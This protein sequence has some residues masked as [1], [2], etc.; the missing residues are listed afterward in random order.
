MQLERASVSLWDSGLCSRDPGELSGALQSEVQEEHGYLVH[1]E[2]RM[3]DS[4]EERRQEMT[5]SNTALVQAGRGGG[6]WMKTGPR[7]EEERAQHRARGLKEDRE[8]LFHGAYTWGVGERLP[9]LPSC[10]SEKTPGLWLS[11]WPLREEIRCEIF[12]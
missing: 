2:G 12:S 6:G 4:T 8:I 5:Q 7:T 3:E 11:V 10:N 9:L 1:S